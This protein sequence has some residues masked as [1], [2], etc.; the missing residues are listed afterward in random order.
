MTVFI[1]IY[2]F[3]CPYFVSNSFFVEL[4]CDERDILVTTSLPCMCVLR[5]V[6]RAFVRIYPGHNLYIYSWISDEF[7]SVAHLEL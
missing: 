4:D 6:V 3:D 7:G 1:D 5:Y 2:L